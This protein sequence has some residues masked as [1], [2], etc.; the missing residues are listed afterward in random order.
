VDE[1]ADRFQRLTGDRLVVDPF[2]EELAGIIPRVDYVAPRRIED[3]R[4]VS[5]AMTEKY[6]NFDIAV[7]ESSVPAHHRTG[8]TDARGI[9]WEDVVNELSPQ[10]H[11]LGAFKVFEPNVLLR[12]YPE[13]R[14]RE[15]NEQWER[16]DA[17]VVAIMRAEGD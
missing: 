3:D 17:A 6:G 11:Y 4:T 10:P 12:W 9:R 14:A 5:P 15:T 1:V 16:L 13:S 8:P 7:Y 2:S